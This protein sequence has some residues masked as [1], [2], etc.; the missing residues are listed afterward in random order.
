MPP[1]S[2][3]H[4]I[5]RLE[6]E[7]YRYLELT[8]TTME[9]LL[10]AL[11]GL[12][13]GGLGVGLR[14][15]VE[16]A[17]EYRYHIQGETWLWVAFPLVAAGL[18]ILLYRVLSIPGL[19]RDLSGYTFPDY[20]ANVNL[21]GGTISVTSIPTRFLTTLVSIAGG[22]SVGLEGPVAALGGAV[23]SSASRGLRASSGQTKT[24]VACGTAAAVA[25]LFN[26]PLA[27]VFFA[28]EIVLLGAFDL[29]GII[30]VVIASGTGVAV[31]RGLAG[32]EPLYAPGLFSTE[33][34]GG[35]LGFALLGLAVGIGSALFI[36]G[37][38]GV[39]ALA[40]SIRLPWMWHLAVGGLGLAAIGLAE[41]ELLGTG[42]RIITV[43]LR[44]SEAEVLSERMI[45]ITHTAWVLLVFAL[46]KALIAGW[47]LGVGYSGGMFGPCLFSGA[48]LGAGVGMLLHQIAPGWISAEAAPQFAMVGMG[49]ML[50]A[51][52]HAPLTGIFLLFEITDSYSVILPIMFASVIATWLTRAI[53]PESLDTYALSR[54][55]IEL[56]EGREGLRLRAISITS[57]LKADVAVV[58]PHAPLAELRRILMETPQ[59][60]IPVVDEEN[61]LVGTVVGDDLG[62]YISEPELS[63][64]L[65]A[66]D[67]MRVTVRPATQND[68]L[69]DALRRLNRSHLS[70]LPVVD[71]QNRVLG[72]L[73][74][75]DLSAAYDKSILL[76]VLKSIT[77]RQN[78]E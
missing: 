11:V 6:E 7:T 60:I 61:R 50:A 3:R 23:G 34:A 76:G 29:S 74:R 77:P 19:R 25:S 43:L 46:S 12:L 4:L 59:F 52:N 73:T 27:G 2:L 66:K 69:G 44:G 65:I 26:A 63:M 22:A 54:R 55:G 30:L 37:F 9:I 16:A 8:E 33:A 10:A 48:A 58:P 24:F 31:S 17:Q 75:E 51:V 13:A 36:R 35:L 1:L 28:M 38:H 45:W 71:D 56:H 49:A 47:S 40:N 15:A 53:E 21:K 41:P 32:N 20:L 70:R 78:P 72:I 39:R 18:L 5:L 62:A 67:V 64:V 14:F 57:V 68:N 42:D